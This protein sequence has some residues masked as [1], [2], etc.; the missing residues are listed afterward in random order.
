[1]F[2]KALCLVTVASALA[3]CGG[4]PPADE[5]GVVTSAITAG[6]YQFLVPPDNIR[7][8]AET[9]PDSTYFTEEVGTSSTFRGVG[10]QIGLTV[11]PGVYGTS[12]WHV[13][14][15]SYEDSGKRLVCTKID[16]DVVSNSSPGT[17]TPDNGT[18]TAGGRGAFFPAWTPYMD[19]SPLRGRQSGSYD[20]AALTQVESLNHSSCKFSDNLGGAAFPL[21]DAAIISG[22]NSGTTAKVPLYLMVAARNRIAGG[23]TWIQ[24]H[25]LRATFP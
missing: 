6:N 9:I 14:I 20:I 10:S 23:K 18:R 3:A 1:M 22:Y 25:E 8:F 7:S 21:S 24:Y 4:E 2:K 12:K 15:G 13:T 17:S 5:V 19:P 11:D 16:M